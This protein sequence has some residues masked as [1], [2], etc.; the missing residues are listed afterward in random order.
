LN[1]ILTR[2]FVWFLSSEKKN[3]KKNATTP[4][5]LSPEVARRRKIRTKCPKTNQRKH[6]SSANRQSI[7]HM[8]IQPASD[9]TDALSPSILPVAS[10]PPDPGAKQVRLNQEGSEGGSVRS[11]GGKVSSVC[12]SSSRSSCQ[13]WSSSSRAIRERRDVF[14][15]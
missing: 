12:G 1:L 11:S 6:G 8:T 13:E 15:F 5:P 2:P 14:L 4:P 7:N 3:T 10:A 9:E